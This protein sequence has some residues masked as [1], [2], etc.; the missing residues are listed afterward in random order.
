MIQMKPQTNMFLYEENRTK[1]FVLRKHWGLA[2]AERQPSTHY[3]TYFLV[4]GDII[5]TGDIF[6]ADSVS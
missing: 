2:T 3:Q 5:H 4:S 1:H 6:R